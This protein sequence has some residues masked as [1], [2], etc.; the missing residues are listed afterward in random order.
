VVRARRSLGQNFL[1]DPNYQQRIIDALEAGAD[2]DILEIGP[3]TGALT[4]H[5]AG[6]VR[7]LIAVELDDALAEELRRRYAGMATV[8]VLHRDFMAIE[9]ARLGVDVARLK[10][11]GN[12]PYNITTPLLFRLLERTWR[13]LRIVVMVQREV[14]DRI[15]APA[16]GREYGALSVGVRLAAH[17]ERLFHVPPGAF[18][19]VPKV[20]STVLRL[21]PFQPPP[22]TEQ[23]EHDVRALTRATFGWRRKQL[24]RTLRAA[25]G[26]EL[27]DDG[28]ISTARETGIDLQARPETLEPDRFLALSRALR[29]IG[30]PSTAQPPSSAEP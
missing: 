20:E 12:I 24:Q 26:Y 5:L 1:V 22:L 30:R 2:D 7:R 28:I 9:P 19:P 23:E 11:V 6:R 16:G 27:D 29:R 3:G 18:R 25:A 15:L 8:A 4:Q 21:T 17:V 13:P 10:V 14:A